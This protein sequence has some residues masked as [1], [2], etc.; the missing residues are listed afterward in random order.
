MSLINFSAISSHTPCN[1]TE[2]RKMVAGDG[3]FV[4]LGVAKGSIS[5]E[6]DEDW[7]FE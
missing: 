6:I 3:S 2:S 7:L 4:G 1:S 5:R